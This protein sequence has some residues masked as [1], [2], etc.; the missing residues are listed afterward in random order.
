MII[1]HFLS[2]FLDNSLC[3]SVAWDIDM[4]QLQV[5]GIFMKNRDTENIF[6]Q[7]NHTILVLTLI[8]KY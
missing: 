5:N 1:I 7:Y 8:L 3:N 4:L 2:F 6:G